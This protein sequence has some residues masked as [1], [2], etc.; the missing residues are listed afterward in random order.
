MAARLQSTAAGCS[1][2]WRI[3]ETADNEISNAE[4]AKRFFE[5]KEVRDGDVVPSGP[6]RGRDLFVKASAWN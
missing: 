5:P 1:P 3:G 6:F 4:G 2:L